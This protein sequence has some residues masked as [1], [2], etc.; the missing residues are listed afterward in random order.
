[1]KA[2]LFV[3]LLSEMTDKTE[4][5]VVCNNFRTFDII[6]LRTWPSIFLTGI[7]ATTSLFLLISEEIM[8]TLNK[9]VK[10]WVV[11]GIL[12]NNIKYHKFRGANYD[13]VLGV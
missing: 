10:K 13:K 9:K 7:I 8:K 11:K 1:M 2:L 3:A 12:S 5:P 4:N 6:S